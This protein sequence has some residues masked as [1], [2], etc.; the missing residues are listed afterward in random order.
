MSLGRLLEPTVAAANGTRAGAPPAPDL[1]EPGFSE[2]TSTHPT[3]CPTI[4]EISIPNTLLAFLFLHQGFASKF[5]I[6]PLQPNAPFLVRSY[7]KARLLKNG[8]DIA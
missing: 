2:A 6:V 4:T 1:V 7:F 8:G 5:P 3:S